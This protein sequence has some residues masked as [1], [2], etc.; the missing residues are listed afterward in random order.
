MDTLIVFSHLRW[1]FVYQRP[2]HL[3]SRLARNYRVLFFEEPEYQPGAPR[4]QCSTPL[5][6]LTVCRPCT[7]LPQPGFDDAQMPYLLDMAA[8]LCCGTDQ[9]IVWFYTPMALPLLEVLPATHVVYD[10]MDELSAFMHS[11]SALVQ[12]EADLLRLADLVF[13]GGPSL[14][15]AKQR[16]S[17][18]VHCFTSSV[19]VAHFRQGRNAR[20]VEHAPPKLGFYG[21]IDERF[22]A[23][24]IAQLA[25]AHDDWRI[26]LVGP[27]VKIDP[28]SLPQRPN[29]HYLGQQPYSA[30]PHYLF[31]WDVCLMPFAI[32]ASTHFIS[33]TKSL[34]YMA[35][36]KPIVS[37][38][39][40]DVVDLHQDVIEIAA[41][42]VQFIEACERML[43][44]SEIA[45][46][47]KVRLMRQKLAHTSWD[48]TAA[49]IHLLLQ[50]LIRPANA[51][52]RPAMK[53]GR[54]R[55]KA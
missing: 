33:P 37:T 54:Q 9:L 21:V 24:I 28:A 22:D 8:Q 16:Y 15:R 20:K 41:T 14:Y 17:A 34:E 2:Q 52:A 50:Q 47:N 51:A 4:L 29:I 12:R 38:P 45:L 6:H 31:E 19:D 27:I 25:D 43:Q 26:I 55:P 30:L 5:P 53:I 11:P 49:D 35:A 3:L 44:L 46:Q 10:C 18:H 13:T 48:V 32:N 23:A 1:D 39:V 40:R 36:E 42:P 7:P